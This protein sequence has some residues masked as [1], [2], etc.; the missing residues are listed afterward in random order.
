MSSSCAWYKL[1]EIRRLIFHIGNPSRKLDRLC[2]VRQLIKLLTF[3]SVHSTPADVPDPLF[4]GSGSE[5]T[6]YLPLSRGSSNILGSGCPVWRLAS[7][8]LALPSCLF[9]WL[10]SHSHVT[11]HVVEVCSQIVCMRAAASSHG[12]PSRHCYI[13]TAADVIMSRTNLAS[14]L[15]SMKNWQQWWWEQTCS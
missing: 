11:W 7:S 5:T 14:I 6:T 15:I 8:P 4:R 10:K 2:K 1:F 12:S 9:Q 3:R 13:H